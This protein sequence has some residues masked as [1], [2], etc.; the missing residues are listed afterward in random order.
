MRKLVLLA[1]VTVFLCGTASAEPWR[2]R[3][4]AG[5]GL[6][7]GGSVTAAIG[8]VAFGQLWLRE[9]DGQREAASEPVWQLRA[10]RANTYQAIEWTLVGIGGAA[11]IT[12]TILALVRPRGERP[13][14]TRAMSL[15][16]GRF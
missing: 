2:S 16:Q 3:R 7:V 9:R 1:L 12:G 6:I 14:P 13:L 10:D 4:R 15:L 5:I 8:G 11:A